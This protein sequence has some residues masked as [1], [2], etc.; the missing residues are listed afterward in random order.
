MRNKFKGATGASIA[1]KAGIQTI[2]ISL[3][4]YYLVDYSKEKT[5]PAEMIK[6][7]FRQTRCSRHSHEM[8]HKR[9]SLLHQKIPSWS[10]MVILCGF[11]KRETRS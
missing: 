2:I 8:L 1:S 10:S 4:N 11:I 6:K 5:A 3:Y 9:H 7:N